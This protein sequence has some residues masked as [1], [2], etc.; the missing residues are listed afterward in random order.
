MRE[1]VELP[2]ELEA[3]SNLIQ[4]NPAF[5]EDPLPEKARRGPG[6]VL[7]I[8][9]DEDPKVAAAV[10]GVSAKGMNMGRIILA[11]IL[12]GG[13]DPSRTYVVRPGT[14]TIDGVRCVESIAKLPE[15]VDLFVVAVGA[16]EVTAVVDD[17]IENRQNRA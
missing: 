3:E 10:V 11:N 14:D 16:A 17:L 1:P 4:Q 15:K 8:G 6:A 13:F 7:P 9:H 12:G 2:P 5:G